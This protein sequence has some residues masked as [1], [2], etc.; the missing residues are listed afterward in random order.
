[1]S[2]NSFTQLDNDKSQW[3]CV[4]MGIAA[5]NLTLGSKI[6]S[7]MPHEKLNFAD[8]EIA[9][10][11]D[12]LQF[13]GQDA[14][15]QPVAGNAFVGGALQAVWIP[16]GVRK[17]PPNVRRGERVELWQFAGNDKYYW[18]LPNLDEN[19]RR[20]ETVLYAINANPAEG[21]AAID[22]SANPGQDV[23]DNYYWLEWSAHNKTIT[24]NTSKKNGEVVE[25]T[26]QIDLKTGQF[27]LQDD[28]GNFA[29]F[30]FMEF[31]LHLQNGMGTFLKLDKQDIKMHAPQNMDIDVGQNLTAK[32][33]SNM[34][35]QIGANGDVKAGGVLTLNGGGSELTLTGGGTTLATPSFKG[36]S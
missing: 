7:V 5:S 28:R 29:H 6:L 8:G 20:L 36:V 34:N 17:T 13:Q 19:L 10:K 21:Q 33:G 22:E 24:L 25:V 3:R 30:D 35:V 26:L 31:L 14:S 32:I 23:L 12:T 2:D 1:M 27:I 18:K 4:S 15:G 9:D 16:S 11:T